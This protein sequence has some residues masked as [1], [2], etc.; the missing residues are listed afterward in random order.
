MQSE[1]TISASTKAAPTQNTVETRDQ[2]SSRRL[3][4]A[5]ELT[6]G[7]A[8]AFNMVWI[9]M[10]FK[11]LGIYAGFAQGEST[12]DTIYL[13]SIISVALTLTVAGTYDELTEKLLRH[14]ASLWAL[15]A[16]ISASTLGMQLSLT[17]S[18][19]GS[20]VCMVASGIVSGVASGLFLIRFGIAFSLLDTRSCVVAA[21]TGTILCSLLFA[22]FLLCES[23]EACL[24]AASTPIIS[25]VLLSYGMH[26][27]VDQGLATPLDAPEAERDCPE[28]N[29]LDA[30]TLRLSL[31]AALVGFS[32]EAVR[33]LYVQMG[34][35]ELGGTGYAIVEGG[36]AFIATLVT[37]V[38]ALI[39]A[40][41][42]TQR[43]A[44]NIYHF[45][46]LLLVASVLLVM[47][48]TTYGQTW[49]LIPHAI[50]SASYSCFGMFMWVILSGVCGRAPAKRVRTFSLV[51][52]G[53]AI[54]P[55]AGMLLGRFVLHRMSI[56]AE[57]ALPL[58]AIGVLAVLIASGFTFS[59]TDL[60]Q[61]MDLLPMERKQRFREK[62]AQVARDYNLSDR[63]QEIMVLLAKGR[64]LPVIQDELCL[65][66][67]TI[68]THRQHIYRKLDIHCQQELID[69][70]QESKG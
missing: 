24:F 44:R 29:D 42:K 49:A 25:A 41:M 26:L 45:L 37:V 50:N 22:I 30:L 54:G 28:S 10:V 35:I 64:N 36:G 18:A 47:V 38:V 55:I 11:S 32:N 60:V 68:S 14:R 16:I 69:L 58:M 62:C 31:C 1:A 66:R 4:N 5:A 9:S 40:N 61:A 15:P 43:M 33:T 46:I 6:V 19:G 56:S 3:P 63:E 48:P 52:A 21:A 34:V 12:L 65:S 53:W 67:S 23:F 51:R 20:I 39:L 7:A 13:V 57:T 2:T 17:L 8:F 70:V 59:E 27:S